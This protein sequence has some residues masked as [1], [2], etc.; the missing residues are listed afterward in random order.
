MMRRL[1]FATLLYL[2]FSLYSNAAPAVV[3]FSGG[4][5]YAQNTG[6]TINMSSGTTT[7]NL[8]VIGIRVGQSGTVSSV[9]D[10]GGNSWTSISAITNGAI[11]VQFW[12]AKNITGAS[13]ASVSYVLSG[14]VFNTACVWEISGTSTTSPFD[15]TMGS[16]GGT[17]TSGNTVTTSSYSTSGANEIVLCVATSN[18]TYTSASYSSNDS[19]T[20]DSAGFGSSGV[21]L[22]AGAQHKI[23]S[24]TQSSITSSM[25]GYAAGSP[26]LEILAAAGFAAT[27]SSA[28]ASQVGAFAVG[29]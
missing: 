29:P 9:S 24:S 27:A 7:G 11:L 13:P 3:Q 6:Q 16:V 2:V 15:T 5:Q 21:N 22:V 17:G 12:Y 23:Y 28:A 19:S 10:L 26:T 20:L 8:L 18:G 25:T 1:F 14:N 4:T